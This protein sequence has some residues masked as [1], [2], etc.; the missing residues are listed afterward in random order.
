[1]KT[2]YKTIQ[3]KLF[4]LSDEPQGHELKRLNNLTFIPWQPIINAGYPGVIRR[5]WNSGG[6]VIIPK[7]VYSSNIA[8]TLIA[9]ILYD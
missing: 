6:F 4:N 9:L 7:K 2:L 1:M 8:F 3:S 5:G